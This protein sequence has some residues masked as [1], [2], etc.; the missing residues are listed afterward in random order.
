MPKNI[1]EESFSISL[2]SVIKTVRGERRSRIHNFP[3][4]MFYLTELKNF[5]RD[6]FC[7]VSQKN[8]GSEKFMEKQGEWGEYQDIPSNVFV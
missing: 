7:A 8:S 3:S 5:R 2:V 4:K 1:V 6:F